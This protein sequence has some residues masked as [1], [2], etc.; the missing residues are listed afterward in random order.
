MAT[1]NSGLSGNEPGVEN[2]AAEELAGVEGPVVQLE[3]QGV[4]AVTTFTRTCDCFPSEVVV[5][6]H[7]WCT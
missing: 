2:L 1:D 4:T 7:V 5:R 6:F 3:R